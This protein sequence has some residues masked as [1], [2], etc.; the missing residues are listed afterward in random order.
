MDNY[1]YKAYD[2]AGA[3]HQGKIPATDL[4]SARFKLKESGMIPVEILLAQPEQGGLATALRFE[5]KPGLAEIELLTSKLAILLENGV[6]IDK[7]LGI[8]IN[9]IA[10]RKLKQIMTEVH[11]EIRRGASLSDSLAKYPDIFDPLY[12]SIVGIGEAAGSLANAFGSIASNLA[13]SRQIR[14]RTRQA[15]LYPAIIFLVCLLSLLFVFNIIVPK[16]STIFASNGEL[17]VYTSLLLSASDF[18]RSYQIPMLAVIILFPLLLSKLGKTGIFKRAI[19]LIVLK[20][21][22]LSSATMT[23]EN[24][25]FV[26]SLAV[27]LKSGVVLSDAIEHAVRSIGNKIIRKRLQTVKD[28]VRQGQKLSETMS[29][30]GFLDES[31]DGLLEVGEQTGNLTEIFLEME[32]RMR[33]EYENRLDNLLTLIE[34]LMIVVMGI[35]VGTVVVV[36]MLS[37]VSVNDIGI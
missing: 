17:P 6:K 5:R 33:T 21:P 35:I 31:F 23:L 8:A 27:L 13:F 7:A 10:N 12:L 16:F 19:D 3:V 15:M 30:T 28:K 18:V 22:V 2:Q 4:D 11:E 36:M 29:Q 20:T 25:R 1:S 32:K 14:S 34:P 24:L 37:L 26:S 9:G